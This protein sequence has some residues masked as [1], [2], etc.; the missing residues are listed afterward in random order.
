MSRIIAGSVGGRRIRMPSGRNTRPTTDR[1]REAI[2]SA[3]AAW[4]GTADRPPE[5]ALAGLAFG[6]LYAGS[7]AVG[8]EAA[9]RGAHPVLLV[10]QDRAT[11]SL[12]RRNAAE[13]GL[14]VTVRL[15]DVR[16]LI[17]QPAAP[18]LD[19]VFADPPYDLPTPALEALLADL[20]AH[21]WLTPSALVVLERSRRTPA[22]AWP[23]TVT[24][25]WS[26]AYGETTVYF[27]VRVPAEEVGP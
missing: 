1:V 13:L 12:I 10:E 17:R 9:S 6:D 8:L 19:V 11:A 18:G 3:V 23:A 16:A 7:G 2:F 5:Q 14:A 27:G 22:P 21:G 15:G 4:A 26:R 24:T 20:D 25:T